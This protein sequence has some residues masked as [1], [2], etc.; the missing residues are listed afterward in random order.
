MIE[1]IAQLDLGIMITIDEE[2]SKRFTSQEDFTVGSVQEFNV[3][4]VTILVVELGD[5]CLVATNFHGDTDCAICEEVQKE[6][7][8]LDES[9]DFAEEI[10]ICTGGE[11]E[12]YQKGQSVYSTGDDMPSFCEYTNHEGHVNYLLIR[13]EE[14]DIIIYRGIAVETENVIL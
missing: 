9:D 2:V 4:G 12:L 6:I 8:Y 7:D 14:K 13:E 5:Y 3:G 10:E 11:N 1:E